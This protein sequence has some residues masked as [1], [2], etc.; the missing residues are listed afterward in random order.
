MQDKT[1]TSGP[2]IYKGVLAHFRHEERSEARQATDVK[3][4]RD[5]ECC[6][7]SRA[8]KAPIVQ[9]FHVLFRL[10]HVDSDGG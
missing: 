4:A 3:H 5:P 10:E 6:A 1:T 8:G 9:D 7:I 2:S